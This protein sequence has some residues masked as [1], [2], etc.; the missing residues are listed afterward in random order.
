[1]S[2]FPIDSTQI[3]SSNSA[4][5]LWP[6]RQ[7]EWFGWLWQKPW[8]C[9][10]SLAISVER[11]VILIILYSFPCV[12]LVARLDHC[13]EQNIWSHAASCCFCLKSFWLHSKETADPSIFQWNL[14]WTFKN[15]SIKDL[16]AIFPHSVC[17]PVRSH[18]HVRCQ[19]RQ[20][21]S[22]WKVSG[23]TTT[24]RHWGQVT[25]RLHQ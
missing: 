20:T 16:S 5:T 2:L 21:N 15:Y 24:Q 19:W 8:H 14:V 25:D 1:M 6:T 4:C 13:L 3:P 10:H 7:T 11:V 9:W 17:L 18:L 22:S 12:F 23:R